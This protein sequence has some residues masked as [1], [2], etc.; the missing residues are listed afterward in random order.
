LVVKT[1]VSSPDK[2]QDRLGKLV[3]DLWSASQ[4]LSTALLYL[5]EATIFK[6]KWLLF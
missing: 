3:F 6:N 2:G 5:G 1:K 4:S